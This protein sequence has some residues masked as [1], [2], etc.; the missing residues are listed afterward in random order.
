MKMLHR[1]DLFCWSQFNEERNI[2]FH[3]FL[4]LRDEG[5]ILID[6]L[7]MSPHDSQHLKE[8]GGADWILITNSSHIRGSQNLINITQAKVAGPMAEKASFPI[9][10]DL[11]LHEGDEPFAGLKVFELHGSKT[12]G[13]LAFLLEDSTLITGDLIRSHQGG[14]LRLLPSNK[15]EDLSQV[16]TSLKRLQN[17]ESIEVVLPGDGFHVFHNALTVLRTIDCPITSGASPMPAS[18]N[19]SIC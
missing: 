19:S 12:P 4:W 2:D 6:P 14:Q 15:C 13:E 18:K 5:N 16:A 10:C 9:H 7:P 17:I 1:P 8:L 11:F 3:S